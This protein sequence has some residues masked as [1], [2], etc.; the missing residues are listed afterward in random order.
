MWNGYR[1]DFVFFSVRVCLADKRTGRAAAGR[2]NF[3]L[4]KWMEYIPVR[5]LHG[6]GCD[7]DMG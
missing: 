6:G 4:Q 3:R 2:F 1:S 5:L 7:D